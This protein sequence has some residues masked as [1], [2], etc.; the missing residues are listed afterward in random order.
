MPAAFAISCAPLARPK[1]KSPV[2]EAQ[3]APG[4]RR[5][6]FGAFGGQYVPETLMPA[7]EELEKALEAARHD[8]NFQAELH[9]LNQTYG[10]RPTPLYLAERLSE[11][12]GAEVWFKR[13]DLLHTGAHKLN[14][15][16]GQ[17]L[18]ARRMGK[19]RIIAE[20]GAGQHG[21]ATATGC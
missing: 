4:A 1:R 20:T 21:L 3:P 9:Q 18:L 10:G 17:V 13:E 16:L 11:H 2:A 19:T 5:G 7:L 8:S 6:R 12:A 15:A 14:N